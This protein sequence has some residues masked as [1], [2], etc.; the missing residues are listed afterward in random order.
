MI[1]T[2]WEEQN[3]NKNTHNLTDVDCSWQLVFPKGYMPIITG[4]MSCTHS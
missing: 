3:M 4:V 1:N 2:C